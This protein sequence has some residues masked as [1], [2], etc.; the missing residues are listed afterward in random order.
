MVR[1]LTQDPI[2]L[3]GGVNL[4]SYA[5]NNPVSFSDPYGLKAQCLPFC[6]APVLVGVGALAAGISQMSANIEAGEEASNGVATASQ[7]GALMTAGNIAL[8]AYI[9]GPL[10]ATAAG[11][12]SGVPAGMIDARDVAFS[13]NSIK[14][15]FQAGGSVDDLAAGLSRGRVNPTKVPP[16]RVIVRAGRLVSLDNRRLAAGRLSRSMMPYRMASEPEILRSAGHFTS[17]TDGT[18]VVVRGTGEVIK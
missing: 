16:L 8:D 18:S 1:S 5:G 11:R 12:T 13:Q 3:A 6:L 2:G 10:T 17:T 9:A 4:Y 7:I 14:A 15:S